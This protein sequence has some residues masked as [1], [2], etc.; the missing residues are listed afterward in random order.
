MAVSE[1]SNS[2]NQIDHLKPKIRGIGPLEE[3][4]PCD[5][6]HTSMFLAVISSENV[7][8]AIWKSGKLPRKYEKVPRLLMVDISELF[9]RY[10]INPK[11]FDYTWQ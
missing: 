3:I 11:L 2:N 8:N 7:R 10:L 5:I 4:K 9:D 1:D 6:G